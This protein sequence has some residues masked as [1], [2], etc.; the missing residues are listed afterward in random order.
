MNQKQLILA[1]TGASGAAA[2]K[3]LLERSQWPVALI[4]TPW[5]QS[6]YAHEC[7]D[8]DSIASKAARLYKHDDLR[9]PPASGSVPTAGMVIAPCSANTLAK[10]AAGIADNLILRAAHCHLKERRPLILV[11]R[12]TPLTTIDLENAARIAAAGGVVMPLTPP[13]FMFGNQSPQKITL[14]DLLIAFAD[15]VLSL[16]GQ[17]APANWETA[18]KQ[19]PNR[20]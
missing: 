10:I 15:R 2:A 12:E 20:P 18:F 19:F 14:Q 7:G 3:V 8:F 16:L 4:A 5:G 11:L 6:V 9:A 13:F 1:V 17:P